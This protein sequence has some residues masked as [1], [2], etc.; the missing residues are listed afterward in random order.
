MNNI[1]EVRA[2]L[3]AVFKGLKEGTVSAKDAGELNNC[4]GKIINTLKVELEFA[5]LRKESPN[6]PFMQY[7]KGETK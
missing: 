5:A 7:E 2:E 4:A 6:I 3:A 1:S